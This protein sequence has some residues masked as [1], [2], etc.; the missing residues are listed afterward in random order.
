MTPGCYK[1]QQHSIIWKN[2][3]LMRVQKRIAL[4]VALK[5]YIKG[6]SFQFPQKLFLDF[7]ATQR[8]GY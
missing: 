5:K 1:R 2:I 7:S 3:T 6:S 8:L 4:I